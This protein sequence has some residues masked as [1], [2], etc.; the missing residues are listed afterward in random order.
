MW[1]QS[2]DE[3]NELMRKEREDALQRNLDAQHLALVER[4][5]DIVFT[6]ALEANRVKL[7]KWLSWLQG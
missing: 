3:F 4:H 7:P 6:D 5:K 1:K 2:T